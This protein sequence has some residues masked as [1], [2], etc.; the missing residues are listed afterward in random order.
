MLQNTGALWNK[1]GIIPRNE[2][3][4]IPFKRQPHKM[5]KHTQTIRR[6]LPK[7]CLSVFDRFM[8][9]ALKG[10]ISA[11]ASIVRS[12]SHCENLLMFVSPVVPGVHWKVTPDTK[13]LNSLKLFYI[14]SFKTKSDHEITTNFALMYGENCWC[15]DKMTLTI[16]YSVVC[17][18]SKNVWI[19]YVLFEYCIK[20]FNK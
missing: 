3:I 16:K 5:V 1:G 10:L 13:G 6:L 9:L 20:T 12:S 11:T 7:K 15:L 17:S 4:L 18:F 8:G 14:R 19:F 2:L